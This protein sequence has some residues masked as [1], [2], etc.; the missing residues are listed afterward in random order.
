M[1][2]QIEQ[3]R[4]QNDEVVPTGEKGRATSAQALVRSV[5]QNVVATVLGA[6]FQRMKEELE[7]SRSEASRV[8][9]EKRANPGK[10]R[11]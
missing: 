8:T 1:P 11:A 4:T 9:R 6:E 5:A 10:A 2:Q 3:R 7:R